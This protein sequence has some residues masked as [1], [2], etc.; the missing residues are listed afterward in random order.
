MP[1]TLDLFIETPAW[2]VPLLKPA[3]YKAAKGGR[4]GGKSHFFAE[5]VVEKMVCEPDASVVCIREIQKSL[6]FSAKRLIEQKIKDLG[7][8]DMFSAT[9]TEIRRKGGSGVCIFQGMQDHTADSVKSLESFDVA[10]VEEAQ[11]LSR[12]SLDLL[13][14]TIRKPGSELWFSWNPCWDDDPVDAFFG[15]TRPKDAI[16]VAVNATDNP[17]LSDV[18]RME[19]A[20]DQRHR[21][22]EDYAHI[23][24]G[25]YK[26]ISNEQVFGGKCRIAEFAPG[27]GWDGPYYGADWGF[28]SD[29][30]AA[31]MAW[32]HDGRL[33][34][35]RESYQWGC[36][37]DDL[38]DRWTADLPGIDRHVVRADSSQPQ[39]IS[40]V[41]RHGI[42][43]LKAADKW[44]GS[45]ED[46]I[47]YLKNYREIVIHPRCEWMIYESR[48]YRYKVNAAGDPL[49]AIN[50]ADNHLWDALR[51]AL[52]PLIQGGPT[53]IEFGTTGV[54]RVGHQLDGWTL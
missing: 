12:Y 49:P 26:S 2:A 46:G 16:V 36:E 52:A 21:S 28:G 37:L 11:K 18:A 1:K 23:W 24:L 34:L 22:A 25:D 40:Y 32:V 45:V 50:D 19:M 4:S 30:T 54:P 44:P 14:P 20:E 33:W 42:A 13:R 7:V 9:L 51:Y 53:A 6:K 29:P 17:F 5:A 47:T 10:W 27:P 35:E 3:R 41:R 48:R 8:G 43:G 15:K 39:S 38:P 31:I